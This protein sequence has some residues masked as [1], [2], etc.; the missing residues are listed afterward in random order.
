ML[1][2]TREKEIIELLIKYHGQYVTIYDIAQQLAVSS[3]TIHR[4]LKHVESYIDTF[5]IELERVNKKGIRLKGLNQDIQALKLEMTQ[6]QTLDL[7]VEEQKVIILY[8]LI[9]SKHAVKQYSLAQEIGVSIQSLTK[10]LDD[11][12][13]DLALYQL[14]LTRKRG[15]GVILNGTESKKREFLS[16]L[17]VN[18]LNSTSVYSIIENHFVYQ[19]LHQSQQSLVD[20]DR[21]F[22]V[23]RILMDYLGQLPYSLTE[24][25]YLTLTVHIVLSITRMQNN[26]YVSLNDDIYQSVKDTFE[27]EIASEIAKHL[28]HLYDVQFNQAEITFITIHLRGSKRKDTKDTLFEDKKSEQKIKSFV[29]KVEEI[30]GQ[31]F[32][33]KDTLINGLSLHI[34]PA[35][36][37]LESNIETYNP[38]TDMIKYKYPRLFD[39]VSKALRVVWPDL[40][41]PESEVAFIVL[42]FGGSI[43][44][45]GHKF[46]NILVVCSSGIGTSRLLATRLEQVFSEIERITQASV[47]DLNVLDLS[48]YDGIISTV[49]LDIDRPFLTVNP[50][51]P[52]SDIGYVS[53]FLNTKETHH[54]VTHKEVETLSTSKDDI[55]ETVRAGLKLVDSVKIEYKSVE[56]WKQ[57]LADYLVS[58]DIIEDG[59]SFAEQ[60]QHR[61]EDNPSWILRPYPIAIPH[62]KDDMFKQPCILIT[63]LEEPIALSN[64]QNDNHSIKYMLSM[65]IPENAIMTKLVSTISETL[66]DHLENLDDFMQNPQEFKTILEKQ[67]LKQIKQQLI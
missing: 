4:E 21:I 5:S 41:F 17:M 26:E 63:I 51:L 47:S 54:L 8:A 59:Q 39:N 31:Y 58:Q 30:S 62:M 27:H 1:L 34:N 55:L 60:L 32:D 6:Q 53:S 67:F 45:Q 65:F 2:S 66:S 49:N 18:N 33:D 13:Q 14:S 40:I 22:K 23:E 24:S 56:N 35:I 28:E 42:H 48:S 44:N 61:L 16:Q 29:Q 50:L 7:S 36:N 9:Q 20:L 19:S 25:S 46:L 12:E 10:L 64:V 3:R 15:E 38:L 11:L 37:R 43:K 57:H 52:D